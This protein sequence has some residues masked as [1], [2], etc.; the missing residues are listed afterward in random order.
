MS[1]GDHHEQ[2]PIEHFVAIAV[3][4]QRERTIG[5]PL[6]LLHSCG[7]GHTVRS[8]WRDWQWDMHRWYGAKVAVLL[9][10]DVDNETI[11]IDIGR[12]RTGSRG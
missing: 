9:S 5:G 6:L 8:A 4:R 12:S 3:V 7:H 10:F 2:L 11:S 1:A